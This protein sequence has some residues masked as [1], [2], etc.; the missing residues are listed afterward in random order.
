MSKQVHTYAYK[1][2]YI[3]EKVFFKSQPNIGDGKK[4]SPQLKCLQKK[5]MIENLYILNILQN[6]NIIST[7]T[8]IEKYRKLH[9][10]WN[11][12]TIMTFT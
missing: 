6:L 5:K 10:S 8:L 1:K 7:S 3:Q 4:M 2:V 9:F 11:R 12:I